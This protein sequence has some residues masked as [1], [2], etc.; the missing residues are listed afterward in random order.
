MKEEKN[1]ETEKKI[2]PKKEE[3]KKQKPKR[4]KVVVNA[5]N[6][7]ISKK[8]SVEIC[9][10]IKGKTIEKAIR[11]LEEVLKHKKAVPMKQ[12]SPHKKGKNIVG[13]RYPKNAT[14]HFIKILKS[15][16]ANA[17][18]N[19]IEN[20]FISGAIANFAYRPRGRFGRWQRKRTHIN[21][22]ASEKLQGEKRNG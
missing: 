18:A 2:E 12:E 8:Y 3:P 22:I 14:E 6:V 11:E 19:G 7:P 4:S 17:N 21:I 9:R 10:F 15:A 5:K 16:A 1:K 13:G 20:P